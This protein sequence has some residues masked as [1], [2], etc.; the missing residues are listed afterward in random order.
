MIWIL[1]RIEDKLDK[2]DTRQDRMEVTLT[3]NT[4][5]LEEHMRRTAMLEEEFKPVK[6][7]WTFAKNIGKFLGAAI[8]GA[9]AAKALGLF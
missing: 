6:R 5:S 2:L 4:A 8:S 1:N 9:L 3:R 7:D